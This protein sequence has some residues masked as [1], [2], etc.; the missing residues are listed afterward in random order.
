MKHKTIHQILILI[1]VSSIFLSCRKENFDIDLQSNRWRVIKMKNNQ[2][3]FFKKAD[4][5]YILEFLSDTSFKLILDANHC[6]VNY[7]ISSKGNIEITSN[8]FCTYVCCD[9][10]YAEKI[11]QIIPLMTTYYGKGKKLTFEGGGKIVFERD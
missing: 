6:Y 5:K 8:L 11:K 7:E 1:F 9:S 10:N 2:D 4:K 3:S